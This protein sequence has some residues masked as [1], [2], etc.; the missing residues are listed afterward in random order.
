MTSSR[1]N[2][3]SSPPYGARSQTGATRPPSCASAWLTSGS[4]SGWSGSGG[5]TNADE[6]AAELGAARASGPGPGGARRPSGAK[7]RRPV[8]GPQRKRRSHTGAAWRPDAYGPTLVASF[9]ELARQLFGSEDVVDVVRQV[10]K[11]TT[12]VR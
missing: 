6:P 9:A 10:L 12:T 7:Q 3:T 5:S 11:F 1:P 2:A 4:A 8:G